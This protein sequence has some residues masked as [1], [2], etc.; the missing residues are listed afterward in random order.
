MYISSPVF[1]FLG[2]FKVENRKKATRRPERPTKNPVINANRR[3]PLYPNCC[4]FCHLT[5]QTKKH[6]RGDK[7]MVGTVVK[8]KVGELEKESRKGFANRLRNYMT[9]VVQEVVCNRT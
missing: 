2:F 6:G 1:V 5:P 7:T 9:G 3:E 8:V 4:F